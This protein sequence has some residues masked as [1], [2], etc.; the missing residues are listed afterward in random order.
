M[1]SSG[2]AMLKV[3][4]ASRLI[5]AEPTQPLCPLDSI[6]YAEVSVCASHSRIRALILFPL[7]VSVRSAVVFCLSVLP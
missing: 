1:L 3:D 7:L 6:S 4:E 5:R 2:H